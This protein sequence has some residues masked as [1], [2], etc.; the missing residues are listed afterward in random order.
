MASILLSYR[1]FLFGAFIVCNAIICSVAAWNFSLARY[2]GIDLHVDVFLILLGVSGVVFLLPIIFVDLFRKNALYTKVWFECTWV[3]VFWVLE[4]AG[5]SA[6]TAIIP[7]E[8]CVPDSDAIAVN[9]C[10]S[11]RVLLA[12]TWLITVLLV[13]Y[14]VALLV[15]AISHQEDDS[16]VWH[17]HVRFFPWFQIRSSLNSAPPSPTRD[18]HRPFALAAPQ[19][20]RVVNHAELQLS[21]EDIEGAQEISGP[22]PSICHRSSS[23]VPSTRA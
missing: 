14:L 21:S 1:Y 22:A 11:T 19:P 5:A 18:W 15:S 23:F 17:A 4:L 7:P 3:A 12:F 2:T 9:A 10:T 8:L 16:M 20:K 13:I 6:V